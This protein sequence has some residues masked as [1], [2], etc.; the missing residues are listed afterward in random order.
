MSFQ[1]K[2]LSQLSNVIF[3]INIEPILAIK[4]FIALNDTNKNMESI[5]W[6]S[7]KNS[8]LLS[9]IYGTNVIVDTKVDRQLLNSKCNYVLTDNPRLLFQK[10]LSKYFLPAK[11]SKIEESARLASNV[12]LGK[13]CYIGHNVIIEEF[14]EIGDNVSIDH[15]TVIKRNTLIGHNVTIGANCTI[16]GVGFGYEKDEAGNYQLIPHLGNIKIKNNVEIGNNT[17][18]DRAVI[19]S[20][21]IDNN[22]K[23]DNLVHIAHGVV[24]NENTV[25]IANAM[26]GGSTVIGK[27]CWIAPS[28]TVINKINIGDNSLVGIG[29]VVI[30]NVDKNVVVVGNPAKVLNTSNKN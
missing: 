19:G 22:V 5:T 30:R 1:L 7:L 2:D 9:E 29:A 15:N 12:T 3:I 23:I 6:C 13:N 10:I 17:C 11:I 26:I 8:H 24:V 20:T 28:G 16:G 25:V 18:I 21:I 14:C 27:N 4:S